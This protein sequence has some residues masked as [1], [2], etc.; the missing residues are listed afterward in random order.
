M[1][2]I[3]VF[4]MM[5]ILLSSSIVS[6]D[7][8]Q[9]IVQLQKR[10]AEVNYTIKAKAQKQGFED[11]ILQADTVVQSYPDAAEAWVWRGIIKSSYAGV[12]GGLGA[13]SL[14]KSSK[15]DL[16]KAL[17]LNDKALSGSAYT[18][19]GTLYFKVPGWPIGF[20]DGDKAKSLLEKALAIN[21]DGIDSNYFYGEFLADQR[22]YAKAEQYLLKAQQAPA[23][24]NRPL[25]DKGRH[26]EIQISLQKVRAQLKN[27]TNASITDRR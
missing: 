7:V 27:K 18:S 5:T 24:P 1:K 4:L 10:W 17:A 12:K 26:D 25:A 9:D 16:E 2:V 14:A 23:R 8:Q 19:L 6:A 22:F 11:L 3:K 21:P 15:A 13:M 20:G